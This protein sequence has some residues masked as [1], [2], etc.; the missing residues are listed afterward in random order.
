[1]IYLL[2]FA[3]GYLLVISLI[4]LQNRKNFTTLEPAEGLRFAG[5]PPKVSICIPARNEEDTIERSVLSAIEQDYSNLQVLVLNDR[6]EDA[7]GDILARLNRRHPDRL[8]VV[9]GAPLPEEWMG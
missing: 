3:T 7:T 2:Y 1:M 8:T 6:S 9:N 5:R 4:L